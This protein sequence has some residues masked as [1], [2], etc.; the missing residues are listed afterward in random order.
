MHTPNI[1]SMRWHPAAGRRR[2]NRPT[3]PTGDAEVVDLATERAIRLLAE[4]GLVP[5]SALSRRRTLR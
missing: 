3:A 1:H 2:T 5:T 4:A